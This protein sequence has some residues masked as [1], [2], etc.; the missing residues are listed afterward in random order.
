[1]T[2]AEWQAL[3]MR[4]LNQA[5]SP[6]RVWR[7]NAGIFRVV[8]KGGT[9]YVHG[10]PEGASDLVGIHRPDGRHVAV[11]NK[12]WNDRTS[13]KR[14]EKQANWRAMIQRFGGVSTISRPNPDLSVE[15]NLAALTDELL[16]HV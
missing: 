2:E 1:M 13:K 3:V 15:D 9:R 16:S 12:R 5:G 10:A 4:H 8:D 11:E 6:F 7:Q 14:R